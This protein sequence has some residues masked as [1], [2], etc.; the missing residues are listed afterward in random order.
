MSTKA[1]SIL[2]AVIVGVRQ[3]VAAFLIVTACDRDITER[4][5]DA[6]E[7]PPAAPEPATHSPEP[8]TRAVVPPTPKDPSKGL[9]KH[10]TI[11]LAVDRGS[12]ETITSTGKTRDDAKT[13]LDTI[14]CEILTAKGLP[15][16]GTGHHAVRSSNRVSII[17][18]SATYEHEE[19][20][21]PRERHRA[22]GAAPG[23]DLAC[24]QA[25]DTACTD[26]GLDPCPEHGIA[27]VEIDDRPAEAFR[28]TS[29]DPP[30]PDASPVECVMTFR[31]ADRTSTVRGIG[32]GASKA[33]A[34]HEAML[35]AC[36]DR[37][38][39]DRVIPQSVDGIPIDL[40]P[41]HRPSLFGP[42]ESG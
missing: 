33:E 41:A 31:S 28:A 13:Q 2:G 32:L 14:R 38:C 22:Q 40:L 18:G 20:F 1:Y 36:T 9:V 16:D 7:P 12:P 35:W 26:A 29:P 15:C 4:T 11:T 5:E 25:L 23:R 19:Q 27:V 3:W 30:P 37:A 8:A 10:C 24:R 6:P 42:R 17:N 21:Q 39:G 34:C